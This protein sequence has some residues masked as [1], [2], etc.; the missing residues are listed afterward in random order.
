MPPLLLTIRLTHFFLH[1]ECVH[2]KDS[3]MGIEKPWFKY[4][5]KYCYVMKVCSLDHVLTQDM[6]WLRNFAL[7]IW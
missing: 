1:M 4:F 3:R 5:S 7:E 6:N 2:E